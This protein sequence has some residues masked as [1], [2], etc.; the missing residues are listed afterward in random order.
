MKTR[1]TT[2]AVALQEALRELYDW[3][4]SVRFAYARMDT[5]GDH[6]GGMDDDKIGSGVVG[7]DLFGKGAR[8]SARRTPDVK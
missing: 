3:A 7:A 5:V 4:E 8:L 1:V 2:D 6:L